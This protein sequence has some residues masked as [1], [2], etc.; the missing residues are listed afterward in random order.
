M[1]EGPRHARGLLLLLRGLLDAPRHTNLLLLE[2]RQLLEERALGLGLRLGGSECTAGG[3]LWA[4]SSTLFLQPLLLGLLTVHLRVA[5]LLLRSP[6]L[7][8]QGLGG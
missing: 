8:L 3:P 5:P 4:P 7:L 1:L 6:V 2:V